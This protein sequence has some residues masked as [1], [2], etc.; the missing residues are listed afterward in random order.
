[1]SAK[2]FVILLTVLVVGVFA[3]INTIVFDMPTPSIVPSAVATEDIPTINNPAVGKLGSDTF[4]HGPS[5]SDIDALVDAMDDNYD[6]NVVLVNNG[7]FYV[8]PKVIIDQKDINVPSQDMLERAGKLFVNYFP[9]DDTDDFCPLN[10]EVKPAESNV[11]PGAIIKFH[12]TTPNV[13]WYA[14]YGYIVKRGSYG[15][16]IAPTFLLGNS[17]LHDQVAAVKGKCKGIANVYISSDVPAVLDMSAPDKVNVNEEKEVYVLLKDKH[18]NPVAGKKVNFTLTTS[19]GSPDASLKAGNDKGLVVSKVTGTDGRATITFVAGSKVAEYK[20][21]GQYDRFRG[22]ALISVVNGSSSNNNNNNN[23]NTNSGSSYSSGGGGSGTNTGRIGTEHITSNVTRE[24]KNATPKVE[25]VPQ[26]KPAEVAP[27]EGN[28]QPSRIYITYFKEVTLG[29]EMTLVLKDA[30]GKLLAGKKVY[31]TGPD[32]KTVELV[33]DANGIVKYT[34]TKEGKYKIKVGDS[35]D[36]ITITVVAASVAPSEKQEQSEA[37]FDIVAA[38]TGGNP[39]SFSIIALL[40]AVL[41]LV[42]GA[43]VYFFNKKEEV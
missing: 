11:L 36:E 13:Q 1:M 22:T 28:A 42:I 21:T 27:T 2:T 43:A 32:G 31:I 26:E 19:S 3:G 9:D 14:K 6:N 7:D 24:D 41:V 40:I 33:S 18:G 25:T 4:I 16:Y 35:N 12:T 10:I 5:P 37:P 17:S 20:V 34:P 30:D 8:P 29:S 23:N 39:A 38:I 15:Y